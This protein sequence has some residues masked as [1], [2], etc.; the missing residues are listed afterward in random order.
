MS[1]Q[2]DDSDNESYVDEGDVGGESETSD[3]DSSDTEGMT[4]APKRRKVADTCG[5]QF[6]PSRVHRYLKKGNY[7][8]RVSMSGAVL[9]T[10]VMEYMAA[11]VLELAGNEARE[12]KR[13]RITVSH[14]QNAIK[15][16]EA[17]TSVCANAIF[18]SD[19]M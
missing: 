17:L 7:A 1:Q 4:A 18:G 5:L 13:T 15:H 19:K 10:G 2:Q 12:H 3:T 9:L 14:I 6:A 8:D 16:D 11:E